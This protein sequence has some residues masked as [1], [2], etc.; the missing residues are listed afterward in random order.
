MAAFLEASADRGPQPDLARSL[1]GSRTRHQWSP[2]AEF[3][4]GP[5]RT[6]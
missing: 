4:R 3:A 2:A 1:W 5:R 6:V